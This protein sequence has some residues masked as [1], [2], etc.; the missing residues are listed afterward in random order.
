MNHRLAKL[1]GEAALAVVV[2]INSFG[3]V[4]MLQ[5]GAGIAAVSSVAYALSEVLPFL[6]LGMWNFLFQTALVLSL[7]VMRRKIVLNYLFSFAVGFAFGAMMDI[8]RI[9]ISRLPSGLGYS[10]FYFCVS[11]IVICFGIALSN[12]CRM[13]IMPTD[14]FPREIHAFTKIPFPR[15]KITFDLTCLII[16]A[17]LTF[18]TFGEIRGLGIGTVAAAFTMGKGAGVIGDRMTKRV[19]FVSICDGHLARRTLLMRIRAKMHANH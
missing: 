2:V 8:H 9:W 19:R 13:P 16:T 18:F 11:W 15:I 6:S 1:R 12:Y 14:L 3:V 4:L 5:S 7:M 10:V 17:A